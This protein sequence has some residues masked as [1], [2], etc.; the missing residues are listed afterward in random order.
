VELAGDGRLHE[1]AL[2]PKLTDRDLKKVGRDQVAAHVIELA[3]KS[4]AEVDLSAG[5]QY[6]DHDWG[7]KSVCDWARLKFSDQAG[8]GAGDGPVGGAHQGAA[9]RQGNGAVS[10][11]RD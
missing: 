4:L 8:S 7:V 9:A 11:E 1:H 3:E 2:R 10:P 5:R 6:L